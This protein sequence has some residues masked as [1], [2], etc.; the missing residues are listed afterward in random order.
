[1][2]LYTNSF[3]VSLED[4]GRYNQVKGKNITAYFK[5]NQMYKMFAEGNGQTIYYARN[6]KKALIGVNRADCS[7]I[8]LLVK[9]NKVQKITLINSPEATFYPIE[10]LSLS[11]LLLKG[12]NWQ[13]ADQPQSK[14]D[15]FIWKIGL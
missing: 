11:E 9:E 12:F 1:M 6:D 4:T 15:I 5:D 14:A 10:E 2:N 8:L 13:Y 3:I 7:N